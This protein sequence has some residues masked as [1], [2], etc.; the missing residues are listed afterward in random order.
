M[1]TRFLLQYV[2]YSLGTKEKFLFII[3]FDMTFFILSWHLDFYM[4]L[5]ILLI[6]VYDYIIRFIIDVFMLLL[7][8][9]TYIISSSHFDIHIIN[10]SR[11][12][13]INCLKLGRFFVHSK[14]GFNISNSNN[15]IRCI[16]IN[17][18]NYVNLPYPFL[19]FYIN[20]TND[21]IDF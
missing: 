11:Q 21:V 8:P 3:F 16:R 13:Q 20:Y 12:F 2:S 9:L 15:F 18:S 5:Y 1:K 17:S 19:I 10:T 6:D 7:I 4:Y 14:C